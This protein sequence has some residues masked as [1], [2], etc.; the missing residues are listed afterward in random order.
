MIPAPLGLGGI[1]NQGASSLLLILVI[2]ACFAGAANAVRELVKERPIYSRERAAGLSAGAYLVSKLV[3]LGLISGLQAMLMVAVGLVGRPLPAH[4]SFLKHLPLVE[5]LLAIGVLAIVSMTLGLLISA[6]VNTSEKTMPLLIVVVIFQ[7]VMTG[8]VFALNGHPGL[9]Q[10]SWISPSRWGYAAVASTSRLNVIQFPAV[11]KAPAKHAVVVEGLRER[12]GD[13][14]P[15]HPGGQ[16]VGEGRAPRPAPRAKASASAKAS[17][18]AQSSAAAAST[19]AAGGSSAAQG[20]TTDPLWKHNAQTWLIDMAA[21][22]LLG[23]IF[24]LLSWQRLV[25][26][27]P[28]RRN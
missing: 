2:S 12:Q 28:G 11:P 9:Q 26:L 22:I 7:V 5:L 25:R 27:S 6:A 16:R 1:N 21:M 18:A 20:L 4:G 14:E 15:A 10:V 24:T 19:A 8:G 23:I 13:R 3:I 17:P